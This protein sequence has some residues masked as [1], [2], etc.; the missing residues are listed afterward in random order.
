MSLENTYNKIEQN[1]SLD[2]GSIFSRS[3]DLFK[4]VWLQGFITL[5]LTVVTI[6]PFYIMLYIP[7]I[8]LGITDP[9]ILRSDDP[10]LVVVLSM[11]ILFPIVMIGITTFA[12]ALNAA[13]LKICKQKDFERPDNDD[14]FYFFCYIFH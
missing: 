11:S 9:G 14:Y 12:L 3:V 10:P 5:L 7:M 13:F 8:A 2:F 1:Q 6:L 4:K